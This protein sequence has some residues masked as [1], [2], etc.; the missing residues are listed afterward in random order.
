MKTLLKKVLFSN[1]LLVVIAGCSSVM[2]NE[3]ANDNN[4]LV[5]RVA[6][7]QLPLEPVYNRIKKVYLPAVMPSQI[8]VDQKQ[9]SAPLQ[10]IYDLNLKNVSMEKAAAA[11]AAVGGYDH[12]TAS[13]IAEQM[14]TFKA[15]GS[16]DELAL[17]LGQATNTHVVVDHTHR[18][19]RIVGKITESSQVQH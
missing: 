5:H 17:G 8:P 3:R 16:I 19:V 7:S 11:I 4:A 15:L 2:P 9:V 13:S 1:A 12:Y 10:Q 18:Q 6:F 14:V